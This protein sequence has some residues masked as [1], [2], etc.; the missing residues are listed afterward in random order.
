MHK[1][2]KL[3]V[4]FAFLSASFL[5]GGLVFQSYTEY[6][7]LVGWGGNLIANFFALFYALK[8][9]RRRQTM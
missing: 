1:Y 8:W 6:S 7:I 5:A 2:Q 3:T 4:S 9:S